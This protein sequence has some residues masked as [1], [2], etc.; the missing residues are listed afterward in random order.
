MS[1]GSRLSGGSQ[2]SAPPPVAQVDALAVGACVLAPYHG[3]YYE[4]TIEALLTQQ[5]AVVKFDGYGNSEDVARAELR[6]PPPLPAG[7]TKLYDEAS[8]FPFFRETTTG[9][10]RWERPKPPRPAGPPPSSATKPPRPAGPP[11]RAKLPSIRAINGQP[12]GGRPD[13]LAADDDAQRPSPAAIPPALAR[14]RREAAENDER[15][16]AASAST[17]SAVS[18]RD[19]L[20]LAA[21]APAPAPAASGGWVRQQDRTQL[22]GFGV[23]RDSSKPGAFGVPR[24]GGAAAARARIN[25]RGGEAAARA[26]VNARGPSGGVPDGLLGSLNRGMSDREIAMLFG[27]MGCGPG[28]AC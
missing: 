22:G 23:Q 5:R 8:G 6:E 12:V 16:A 14:L 19:G 9:A 13:Y 27:G 25:A 11:P 4:A 26:R 18:A 15:V 28:C 2:A 10:T 1:L 20:A 24:G 7:W 3:E 21:P 17:S